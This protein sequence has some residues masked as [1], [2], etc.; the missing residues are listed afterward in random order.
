MSEQKGA[1]SGEGARG[2]KC[3]ERSRCHEREMEGVASPSNTFGPIL[4]GSFKQA[5]LFL[6]YPEQVLVL[7]IPKKS[8]LLYGKPARIWEL[9]NQ[10]RVTAT[11]ITLSLSSS[12]SPCPPIISGWYDL[13][14]I[15]QVGTD[16]SLIW[17]YI[18]YY[19]TLPCPVGLL[20]LGQC[21]I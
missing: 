8:W 4:E 12:S 5:F 11:A 21:F 16:T 7:H 15:T 1:G 2:K 13:S 14:K 17:V 10:L 6:S 20:I 3:R 18:L 19:A 9:K